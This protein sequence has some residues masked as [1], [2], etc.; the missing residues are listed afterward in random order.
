MTEQRS[1][2]ALG[3]PTPLAIEIVRDRTEGA[4]CDEGFLRLRR[5]VLR[6]RYPD[7]TT[8]AEY[9][10]DL[11]ERDAMDAVVMVL[12]AREGTD[13][14]VCLRTAIRPPLAFRT[15]YS[16]P[17][18]E[19]QARPRLWELPAGLIE[20][21]ERGEPGVLA[22]AARETLEETGFALEPSAF[23]SLGP[24]ATLSPGVIGEKIHFVCAE[25]DPKQ[26]RVPTEDGSPVE[27]RA[28]VR[29]VTLGE[30]LAAIAD[31]RVA[32]VKT[33]VGI[34]RLVERR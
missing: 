23:S 12:W 4:R 7:G 13:T 3:E 14:L 27:E 32:D 29:F 2:G 6:N 15:G 10:Y 30:A 31:G 5:L 25:V 1:R 26:R 11:V 22:C 34:R 24:P 20:P 17:I 21:E 9:P 16:I 18:A 33:E 8:S 19:P 28:E